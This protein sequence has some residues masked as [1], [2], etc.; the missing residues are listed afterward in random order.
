MI[1]GNTAANH[2]SGDAGNDSL[3]GGAG[4]DTLIGGVGIDTLTGGDGSD[5]YSIETVGDLEV[6]IN[7]VAA[8]GG[9]DTVLSSLAA[10]TLTANVENLTLT[11]VAAINGTGNTDTPILL[12]AVLEPGKLNRGLR[13]L[14]LATTDAAFLRFE[15]LR[16][17]G[18]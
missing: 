15:G 14:T 1:T 10:Y 16:L 2:L 8:T 18:G 11:G 5:I 4:N 12:W 7:A 3:N 17:L 13:D 6:E 9:T